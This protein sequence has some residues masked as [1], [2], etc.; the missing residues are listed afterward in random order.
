MNEKGNPGTLVAAHPSN[1]N[2]AT[3][4]L[5]SRSGRVLAPRAAEIADALMRLPHVAGADVLAAEEI[6]SILAALEAIDGQLEG[7]RMGKSLLEHK[8][9]LARELRAFLREFGAT[10][11]A[12][13]DFAASLGGQ[14]LAA[15]IARR[16]ATKGEA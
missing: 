1:L 7:G 11:K 4:G 10:P 15:E 16:R 2:R 5:Y 6:G 8:A 9:R 12:R 13:S 14:N 3:H